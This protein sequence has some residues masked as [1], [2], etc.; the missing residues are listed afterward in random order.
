MKSAGAAGRGCGAYIDIKIREGNE[1]DTGDDG[2]EGQDHKGG[3]YLLQEDSTRG[4]R[5]R[6]QGTEGWQGKT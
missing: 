6:K 3:E 4:Y 1:C 2:R 5:K